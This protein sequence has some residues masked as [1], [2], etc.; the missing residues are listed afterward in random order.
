MFNRGAKIAGALAAPVTALFLV[1]VAGPETP[2]IPEVK[3]TGP[4]LEDVQTRER[5][6]ALSARERDLHR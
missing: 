5:A 2:K 3:S 1:G 6:A 4:R